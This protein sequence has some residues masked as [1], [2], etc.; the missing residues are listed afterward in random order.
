MTTWLR[1]R[2]RADREGDAGLGMI[3]VVLA[4]ALFLLL[5]AAV[6][7]QAVGGQALA[8]SNQDTN[9]ALY[10]AQAGIEHYLT[11]LNDDNAYVQYDG[12]TK[13]DPANGAMGTTGGKR[14]WLPVP[15]A[16]GGQGGARFHYEL[17][18]RYYAGGVDA[19]G[20]T[21]P[22][23]GTIKISATGWSGTRKRTLAADVRRSGFLDNLYYS[24]YETKDPD[25]YIS[26]IDAQ[27]AAWAK[28]NCANK[29]YYSGRHK[30]CINIQFANDRLS[31][32]VHSNDAILICNN[33][34]F[35]A[36]VTTVWSGRRRTDGCGSTS[37]TTFKNPGDPKVVA[38][39]DLPATNNALKNQTLPTAFPRGCLFVGE[40]K[41]VVSGGK[42]FITSPWTKDTPVCQKDTWIPIP[43]NGVIYVDNAVVGVAG[44]PNNWAAGTGPCQ[45]EANANSV[46][47]PVP[48][49]SGWNYKCGRGDVF[50]QQENGDA[51]H[52]LDGRL[53]VAAKGDLYVTGDLQYKA[54]TDAEVMGSMLGLIA[55]NNVYYWHPVDSNG[56]N[57]AVAGTTFT[58]RR[59][60]AALLSV[61]HSV[62]TMNYWSGASL[63]TLNIRGNM[64]QKYR[65]IVKRGSSGYDKN[66]AFD[67]RLQ[68]AAPPHF[69]EPTISQFGAKNVTEVRADRTE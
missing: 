60:D 8:R 38:R 15:Q 57:I 36:A 58:N 48:G 4:M 7:G 2:I 54:G 9:T 32:P 29:Y 65:G 14:N 47:Y 13:T 67:W 43:P 45:P 44:D 21:I 33:A 55:D 52:G 64:T 31:G 27:T 34:V 28:T 11:K 69:I 18:L 22:A 30:N 37:G 51:A 17:D 39:V 41:I 62:T 12:K 3:T 53:T 19:A 61:Q 16:S 56:K 59:V 24:D 66:Y 25:A 26:S 1:N 40:T 50:I 20:K 68:L 49:E 6:L 63:G 42:L 10:A 5:S 23:T 46:G 35:D